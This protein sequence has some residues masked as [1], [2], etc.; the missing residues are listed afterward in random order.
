MLSCTRED[1]DHL[2]ERMH[3]CRP[4]VAAHKPIP[5]RSMPPPLLPRPCPPPHPPPVQ[6]VLPFQR[7]VPPAHPPP[8]LHTP[9]AAHCAVASLADLSTLRDLLTCATKPPALELPQ[10]APAPVAQP[11]R[12]GQT[13]LTS[14]TNAAPRLNPRHAHTAPPDAALKRGGSVAQPT[15]TQ[16]L[17]EQVGAK[18]LKRFRLESPTEAEQRRSPKEDAAQHD[19]GSRIGHAANVAAAKGNIGDGNERKRP[20]KIAVNAAGKL[21]PG[22][23]GKGVAC[24][25]VP[26]S[27]DSASARNPAR[28][29]KDGSHV[30]LAR[31][32]RP[33]TGALSSEQRASRQVCT[34]SAAGGARER[35]S[36][37]G[38]IPSAAAGR[39]ETARH[40]EDARV[41]VGKAAPVC[42]RQNKR[43]RDV[44]LPVGDVRW[45]KAPRGQGERHVDRP[46]RCDE[47]HE[48][49]RGRGTRDY[50][51]AGGAVGACGSGTR[52]VCAPRQPLHHMKQ[53][54]HTRVPRACNM[55]AASLPSDGD[56]FGC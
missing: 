48:G 19:S 3:V 15:R 9:P 1:K 36:G 20:A 17:Q 25:A 46:R 37:H 54:V 28:P 33:Y 53:E 10:P 14:A 13:V 32:K 49:R 26:P 23:V 18:I 38:A 43:P 56:L 11:C 21:Q 55:S 35:R 22:A 47:G 41:P 45:T 39:S 34:P 50:S 29:R 51:A 27:W 4:R 8:P 52:S 30:D 44:A 31:E 2:G 16:A 5:P 40:K 6:H 12:A 7:P 42:E 24:K